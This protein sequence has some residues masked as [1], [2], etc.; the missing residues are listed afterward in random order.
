M[1]DPQAYIESGKLEEYVL[2]LGTADLMQEVECMSRVFP[3]IKNELIALQLRKETGDRKG[4]ASSYNLLGTIYRKQGNYAGAMQK[5]LFALQIQEAIDDKN[6]IAYSYM[7][8]GI[9]YIL[10]ANYPE[11]IKKFIHCNENAQSNP[12]QKGNS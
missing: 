8:I 10:Q 7:N 3:E 6:G 9:I 12:K 5:H 4:V 11:A 1:I 2:G